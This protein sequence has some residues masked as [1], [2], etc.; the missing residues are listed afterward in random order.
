M[1]VQSVE[2]PWVHIPNLWPT[3]TDLRGKEES[4]YE[5]L[6]DEC[7]KHLSQGDVVVYGGVHKESRLTAL[8]SNEKA[9]MK[10]SG[11][12]VK[13]IKPDEDSYLSVILNLLTSESFL[14]QIEMSDP[15]L[16]GK[17]P[18]GAN[19]IFM[20]WYRPP[21][22][23]SKMDGLGPHSDDTR[24]LSSPVI[25][26]VTFCEPHGEKLFSFSEKSSGKTV[27]EAELE[28]GSGLVMLEDCQRD[29]KHSV[30]NRKTNSKGKITGGR[31]NLTIRALKLD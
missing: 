13:P 14:E 20:N 19:A 9:A 5:V 22:E 3:T 2:R 10:Y 11:R 18:R 15:R 23:T 6:L 25:L 31:I 4:V 1:D 21:T 17:L 28:D 27:W 12:I 16:K 24:S 7:R 29:Y 30:S 26:S 8:F